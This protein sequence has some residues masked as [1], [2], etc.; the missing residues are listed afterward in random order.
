MAYRMSFQPCQCQRRHNRHHFEPKEGPHQN[1][2]QST[3]YAFALGKGV[4]TVTAADIVVPGQVEILNP[5]QHIA[6][7]TDKNARLE[8][9][10]MVDT[11]LGYVPKRFFRKSG[12]ISA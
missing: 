2:G 11:G 3:P 7:L 5:E 10:L 1:F 6:E 4:K 8:A 9:E 12:L